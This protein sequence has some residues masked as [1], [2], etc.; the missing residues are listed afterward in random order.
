MLT[1]SKTIAARR[2]QVA[3]GERVMTIAVLGAT[4]GVGSRV[5][6]E[7]LARGHRVIAVARHLD[8]LDA[9]EGLELRAGDTRRPEDLA[10]LL[11]GSDAIVVAI[12]WVDNELS[13]VLAAVRG[14][15][16]PRV[17]VVVGAGSLRASDG[18]LLFEVNAARGIHPPTSK[19]ALETYR[20]LVEV[21]DVDWT[22]ASPAAEIFPGERTAQFR[23]G[24]DDLIVDAQGL[25]RISFEDFA[26][27]I[28]DELEG[29][30]YRRARFTV[31]Y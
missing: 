15:R 30:R 23:W 6:V 12:R 18:R 10:R 9:V 21:D 25:S 5:R 2:E 8:E 17:I 26:V 28:L 20:K 3:A 1:E 27:A 11:S 14:A 31:A 24:S 22:A 29:A 16:I 19:A 4:G 13:D 7:A